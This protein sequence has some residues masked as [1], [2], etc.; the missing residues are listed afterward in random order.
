MTASRSSKEIHLVARPQGAPRPSDFAVAEVAVPDPA[1]GQVLVHNRF[2]SVDPYMRGR[3][4]DAESYA[5]PFALG[6]VMTGMSVGEVVASQSPE[7]AVGDSVL[8][9]LG[10]REYALGPA[11]LFRRVPASDVPPSAWLGVLGMV[12]LTAWVGMLEIA[13]L[14]A[15]DVVF[16]SAAAGAVGSLAG[17]IAK[18]RGAARVVGS[19]G[20]S[21]KVRYVCDELGFDAAFDYH[22]GSPAQLL[23]AA[24]PDGI[25]V[26]YD[27]VGGEHLEAAIGALR[28][29]GRAALCGAISHYNADEPAAG[30][31]NLG[32][33]IGKRL[34]LRGF[35]VGDHVGRSAAFL[36][37][38]GGWLA[39]GR[40]RLA[41]TMIDGVENAPAAFIGL[42]RGE[43]IGKMLVRIGGD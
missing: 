43:N 5:P 20:S 12:G 11:A 25:D 21:A 34:T 18:L 13:D 27:N 41:E 1:P 6:A 35:L 10:W 30:P 38:V 32:L 19:A 39:E 7:L 23:A 16:V 2:L 33:M 14:Q 37:E 31:R 8:H 42:M 24:A 26:Y 22:E 17:Q 40:I 15:G 36:A 28:L 4:R 9:D 29:H 3:M